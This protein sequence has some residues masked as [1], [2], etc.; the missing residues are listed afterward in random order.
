MWVRVSWDSGWGGHDGDGAAEDGASVS[1]VGREWGMHDHTAPPARPRARRRQ[2]VLEQDAR[3]EL[4]ACT[5]TPKVN[6]KSPHARLGN[7]SPARGSPSAGQS[8]AGGP[9]PSR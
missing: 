6:K 9:S 2:R 8:G 7:G 3:A 1:C 4:E 5:F